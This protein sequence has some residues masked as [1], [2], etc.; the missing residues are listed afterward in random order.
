VQPNSPES[1]LERWPVQVEIPVAW[2]DMDAFQHVNNT[3]YLRWFETARIRYFEQTGML[4][5]MK[6]QGVGPILARASVDY[7]LPVL[8]PDTVTVGAT[9]ARLG[10]TS[11][12]M[13]YRAHSRAQSG[14][15]VAE[16]ESVIVMLDYKLGRKVPL[17]DAL[18]AAI[19]RL[20]ASGKP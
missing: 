18:R 15:L 20:E 19:G 14:A 13:K 11:Y 1:P 16:G 4:E 8:Y 5:K 2:G 7:R 10:T 9:V 12:V 6:A 17:D 3:I